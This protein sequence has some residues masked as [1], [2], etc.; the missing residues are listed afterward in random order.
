MTGLKIDVVYFIET[1]IQQD[2]VRAVHHEKLTS[3]VLVSRRHLHHSKKVLFL[4][5]LTI[6]L[7][8]M[9]HKLKSAVIIVVE[10]IGKDWAQKW[11]LIDLKHTI[12]AFV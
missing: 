4:H 5:I 8:E 7:V 12:R 1:F 11:F 9:A 10:L 2:N 3:S 6:L